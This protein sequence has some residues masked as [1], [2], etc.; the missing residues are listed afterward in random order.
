MAAA[1]L[2]M[3]VVLTEMEAVLV[4][5]SV[6]GVYAVS[7]VANWPAVMP[8]VSVVPPS[9]NIFPVMVLSKRLMLL[10]SQ[11]RSPR[12]LTWLQFGS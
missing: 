3:P 9:F 8:L 11:G 2:A 7:T 4:A 6:R 10:P 1:L 5:V 12:R